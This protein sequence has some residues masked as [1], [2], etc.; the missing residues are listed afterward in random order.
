MPGGRIAI[1]ESGLCDYI[2]VVAAGRATS[3][4]VR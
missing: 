2:S 4:S 3:V 1:A